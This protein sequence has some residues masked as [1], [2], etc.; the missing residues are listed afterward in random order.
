MRTLGIYS[1]SEGGITGTVVDVKD[2]YFT[3]ALKNAMHV[4]LSS[5]ITTHH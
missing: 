2:Y 1:L 5:A 4:V 3:V